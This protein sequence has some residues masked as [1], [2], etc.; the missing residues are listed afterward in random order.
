VARD[1]SC[2]GVNSA[3]ELAD[4]HLRVRG[5]RPALCTTSTR[6]PTSRTEELSLSPNPDLTRT[7]L[8][9]EHGLRADP[10]YQTIAL[11]YSAFCDLFEQKEWRGYEYRNDIYWWHAA[12]F[13]YPLAKAQGLGWVQE[14]V[15]RLT[16]SA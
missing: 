4:G 2:S 16:H 6:N 9:L 12:S 3:D 8:R 1:R 7:R 14:L 11:G 13:G 10:P 15:S 5:E